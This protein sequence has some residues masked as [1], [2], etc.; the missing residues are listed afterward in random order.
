LAADVAP[1]GFLTAFFA[2]GAAD[3]A[4]LDR[5]AGLGEEVLGFVVLVVLLVGLADLLFV[6]FVVAA[7]MVASGQVYM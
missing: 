6:R 4:V 7:A 2:A 3:F 5:A 1:A